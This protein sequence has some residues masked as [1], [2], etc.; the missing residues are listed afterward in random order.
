M[1]KM[2]NQ[3]VKNSGHDNRTFH[4]GDDMSVRLPS[5]KAYVPQVEKEHSWLPKLSKKL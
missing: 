4:L 3:P 5:A 1:V 2:I